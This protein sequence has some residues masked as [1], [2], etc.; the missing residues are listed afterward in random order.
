MVEDGCLL[1]AGGSQNDKS[2]IKGV[3]DYPTTQRGYEL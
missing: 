2:E 3:P 1:T